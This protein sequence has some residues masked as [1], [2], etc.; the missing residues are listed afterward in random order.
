MAGIF[1]ITQKEK[2]LEEALLRFLNFRSLKGNNILLH[3]SS[4]AY[5]SRRYSSIVQKTAH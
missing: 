5:F 4:N 1:N 3:S 2:T